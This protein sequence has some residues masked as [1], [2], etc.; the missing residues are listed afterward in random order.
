MLATLVSNKGVMQHLN[1]LAQQPSKIPVYAATH[2]ITEDKEDALEKAEK[3]W[4]EYH[5]QEVLIQAQI[6]TI[7]HK[8]LL[9]K[10]WKLTTARGVWNAV[11]DKHEKTALT[12]KVDMH[13]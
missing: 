4:D 8:S 10:V 1:G 12:I 2:I 3:C 9:I 5:Q 6:F 7:I 11:C 13:Q